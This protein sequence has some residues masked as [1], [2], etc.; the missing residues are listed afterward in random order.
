[1]CFSAQGH[2]I[3]HCTTPHHATPYCRLTETYNKVYPWEDLKRDYRVAFLDYVR[4]V[5][6]YMWPRLPV[7]PQ[8]CE[9]EITLWSRV[10]HNKSKPVVK[11]MIEAAVRRIKEPFAEALQDLG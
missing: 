6:A 2:A 8:S 7:T 11:G 3:P 4:H 5:S 9:K 10:V 1:M